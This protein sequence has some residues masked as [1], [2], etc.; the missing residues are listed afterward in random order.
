VTTAQGNIH[1]KPADC[2][3][4]NSVDAATA[5]AAAATFWLLLLLL[6]IPHLPLQCV[7]VQLLNDCGDGGRVSKL[8]E[9]IALQHSTAQQRQHGGIGMSH[10]H[11]RTSISKCRGSSPVRACAVLCDDHGSL[12]TDFCCC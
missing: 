10:R 8:T 9:C 2:L 7:H 11:G 12:Y 4:V 3:P 5:H 1:V 6:L